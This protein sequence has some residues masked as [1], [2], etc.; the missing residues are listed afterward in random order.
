MK[1]IG[2]HVSAAGGVFNAPLN[3]QKIGATAYALFTKSQRQ[4]VASPLKRTDIDL[5]N[6][7]HAFTH[8]DK[9]KVVVHGSYLINLASPDPG[10]RQKSLTAFTEEMRRCR[11]LGLPFLNFHPGAHLHAQSASDALRQEA[12]LLTEALTRCKRVTLLVETTAGQGSQLGHTFD[13]IALLLSEI[14][15]PERV[16][17]CLDTCHS[18][19]AGYDFRTEKSYC[20]TLDAFDSVIGLDRLAAVHLNDSK[21]PFGSRKDRHASIGMGEIGLPAFRFFMQDSRLESV[22]FILET[23]NSERWADEIALLHRL[24]ND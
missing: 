21:T 24:E 23:P 8:L 3:A 1:C 17:V 22:P 4:W 18:F 9:S 15:P 13:E 10:L 7:N 6:A 14:K 20:R 5:F 12:L 19:N 11:K 16:K 2:A